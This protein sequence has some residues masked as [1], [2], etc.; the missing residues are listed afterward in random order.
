[1]DNPPLADPTWGRL[2]KCSLSLFA[3]KG[4]AATGIREIGREAGIS[5]ATLYHYVSGKEDILKAIMRD[6]L[7][8]LLVIADDIV[9][10]PATATVR[11]ETLTRAHVT[12][13]GREQLS[14]VVVD[15][16]MRSLSGTARDE[17][18]ELRD[19]YEALWDELLVAGIASGEFGISMSER[20]FVRLA[21]IQMSTG[22]AYWYRPG[23]ALDLDAIADYFA[24]LAVTMAVEGSRLSSVI[25]P[26]NNASDVGTADAVV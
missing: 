21:M 11:L 14:A 3:E 25:E 15:S 2:L 1:M 23:R 12:M 19:S 8:K 10:S 24:G 26:S 5:P 22:V 7:E 6:G 9:H 4:F 13:H 17:I 20:R 16:E 18:I